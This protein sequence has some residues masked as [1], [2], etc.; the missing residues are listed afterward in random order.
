M[1]KN[2]IFIERNS[3]SDDEFFIHKIYINNGEFVKKDILLAEVEGA[4]AIFE[5]YSENEGYFF[6]KHK[7]GDYIDME[8]PFAVISDDEN[9]DESVNNQ[10]LTDKESIDLKLNLSKPAM[11]YIETTGI[12]IETLST[13]LKDVE[14]ITVED[15]KKLLKS[16]DSRFEIEISEQNIKKWKHELSIQEGREPLFIIGG[17]YGAYQVLDLIIKSEQYFVKGYFDDGEETKLDLLG[18]QKYGNTELK[19]INE[20]LKSESIKNVTVAISNNPKLRAKFV[21]LSNDDINIVTLIHPS[22]V[23]GQNTLVGDG[24][25]IFANVHIGPDSEIGKMSFISSNSTIEH[26][27]KIGA[28]FCCGPSFSTSG[29]V[30]IGNLVRTGINVGIEPFVK[31]G[32]EVVL[33]SGTIITK[34]VENFEIIK[35]NK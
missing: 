3:P 15:I 21:D 9:Y 33:A 27:N 13:K 18:I 31:I 2:E 10:E 30:E 11:K 17:G 34:N 14:L 4:K 25:I 8:T 16:S 35:S 19:T 23:I 6:T 20:A 24:S 5:I 28:A 12:D 26:H 1:S 7:V 22:A 29:I 32:D